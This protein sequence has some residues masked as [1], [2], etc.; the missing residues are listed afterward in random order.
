MKTSLVHASQGLLVALGLAFCL[1]GC[2]TVGDD[3]SDD[4]GAGG[5]SGEGSGGSG[6]TG[7]SGAGTGG[8]A[9]MCVATDASCEANGDCCSFSDTLMG[10]CVGGTCYDGC[11]VDA[12]CAS[13]CCSA[14]QS[15][16]TACAPAALC[17][18]DLGASC[19]SNSD[20]CSYLTGE[21]YCI[22][23]T[24]TCLSTCTTDAECGDG[25]CVEIDVGE[26]VCAPADFC[27]GGDGGDG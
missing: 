5:E 12:D 16:G 2:F 27:G 22:S 18:V 21:G 20:C 13:N 7:G 25:C 15:G 9:P 17:C 1:P 4:A 19:T 8:S 3:D 11:N 6:G 24:G 23:D 14:L 10:Y 26:S